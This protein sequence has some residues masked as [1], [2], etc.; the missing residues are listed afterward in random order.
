M[1]AQLLIPEYSVFFLRLGYIIKPRFPSVPQSLLPPAFS[2]VYSLI[3]L[4]FVTHKL[5]S[6]AKKWIGRLASISGDWLESYWTDSKNGVNQGKIW[7]RWTTA[8]VTWARLFGSLHTAV[9]VCVWGDP[10]LTGLH[11]TSFVLLSC[12]DPGRNKS[13]VFV[14]R[15]KGPYLCLG[16]I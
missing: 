12:L 10:K 13:L 16:F 9:T 1:G 3:Q 4:G 2:W 15:K 14:I 7:A 5:I 8:N 6:T 11:P